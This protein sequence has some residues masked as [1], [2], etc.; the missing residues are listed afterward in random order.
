MDIV[1]RKELIDAGASR[2]EVN[3]LTLLASDLAK[4]KN[5][6]S[7][8][9]PSQMR[10]RTMFRSRSFVFALSA[11]TASFLIVVVGIGLI[12]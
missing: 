6:H 1:I 9:M 5:D 10:L 7:F 4:L 11:I 12:T 2:S 3:E 8:V